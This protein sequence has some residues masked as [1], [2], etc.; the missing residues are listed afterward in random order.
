MQFFLLLKKS[1]RE[2]QRKGLRGVWVR[3]EV[4]ALL[5]LPTLAGGR[6]MILHLIL[7]QLGRKSLTFASGKASTG[8]ALGRWDL[9]RE[10]FFSLSPSG[11]LEKSISN[12]MP[13]AMVFSTKHLSYLRCSPYIILFKSHNHL[14]RKVSLFFLCMLGNIGKFT[15]RLAWP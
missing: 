13:L 15:F 4:W 6:Q 3:M 12:C 2:I 5:S 11:W 10:T 8:S 7:F 14:V 9:F 1:E